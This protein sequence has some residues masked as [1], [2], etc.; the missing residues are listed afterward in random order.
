[1]S[2]LT[3]LSYSTSVRYV[4]AAMLGGEKWFFSLIAL[5]TEIVFN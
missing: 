3:V 2:S 4:V 1:M 5:V